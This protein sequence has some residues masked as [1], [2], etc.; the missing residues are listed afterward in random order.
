[1]E[2]SGHNPGGRHAAFR[3]LCAF[4]NW[5]GD[6]AEP[7]ECSNPIHKIMAQKVTI[8]PLELVSHEA[9]ASMIKFANEEHSQGVEIRLFFSACLIPALEQVNL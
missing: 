8:E 4:L 5:Y 9:I 3:S 6:E 7:E 2:E 1:M